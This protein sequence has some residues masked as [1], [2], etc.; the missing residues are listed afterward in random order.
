[1]GEQSV[2]NPFD[3]ESHRPMF[4]RRIPRLMAVVLA[5]LTFACESTEPPAPVAVVS[6]T[7]GQPAL[8]A[9][10]QTIGLA[11]VAKDAAG[12]ELPG[13]SFTWSS[14]DAAIATVSA[15]GLV[16][17]VANGSA[18]ITATVDGVF[19]TV[20]VTV[21]QMVAFLAVTP[22]APQLVSI[23]ETVQLTATAKDSLGNVIA[24]KTATWTSSAGTVASVDGAGVARA[25][26][27]GTAT[28]TATIDGKS[29]TAAVTV[30]QVASRLFWTVQPLTTQSGVAIPTMSVT[31]QD[32]LGTRVQTAAPQVT[33][34]IGANPANGGIAGVA[35]IAAIDGVATFPAIAINNAGNGYTLTASANGLNTGTSSAFDILSGLARIDSVK[36]VG[37]PKIGTSPAYN[38]WITNGA[39]R[40]LTSA[41]VQA[42]I[43]QNGLKGAG[44]YQVSGCSATAGTIPHGSCKP[45]TI[46]LALNAG[47]GL[48]AGGATLRVDL[49]EIG[50]TRATINVPITLV[51]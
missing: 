3:S 1:M 37:I 41:A 25:L 11:A 19:S 30:A 17:A 21:A 8:V 43:V 29:A 46:A 9:L 22:D 32:A 47:N 28:M 35:Q 5:G 27:N 26:T 23:N 48:V 44:G 16:T 51:P 33:L 2:P 15:A 40:S 12:N 31:V 14:S 4:I 42:Y 6:I 36:V 38:V 45:T 39:G 24:G 34:A 13:K 49:N 10:G 50:G 18:T 20:T 7:P